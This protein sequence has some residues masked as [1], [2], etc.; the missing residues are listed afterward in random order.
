MVEVISIKN[1]FR[2]LEKPTITWAFLVCIF[3]FSEQSE[4]R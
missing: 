3:L 4:R 2:I 1:R